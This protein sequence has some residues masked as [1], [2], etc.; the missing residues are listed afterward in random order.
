M[1]QSANTILFNISSA[2]ATFREQ[3]FKTYRVDAI[4]NLSALR[5][6]VFEGSKSK[7]AQ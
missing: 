4:F 1:I 6:R 3:L 5:Y 2:A 7:S